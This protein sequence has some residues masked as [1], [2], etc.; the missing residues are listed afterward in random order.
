[1]KEEHRSQITDEKIVLYGQ[2][3]K[4]VSIILAIIAGISLIVFLLSSSIRST[5][6]NPDFYKDNFKKANTYSELINS[7]IPS[8]IMSSTISNDQ[9]TNF[10]AQKGIIY[11]VQHTIPASW[12]EEKM[13]ALIDNVTKFISNSPKTPK[14]VVKLNDMGIYLTQI[15]DGL[16]LVEQII[17]SCEDAGKDTI[18][19]LFNIKIDCKNMSTNLDQ[20]KAE[21]EKMRIKVIN[22]KLVE[23]DISQEIQNAA[24]IFTGI[25][26]YANKVNIYFW[27]SLVVLIISLLLIILL[28]IKNIYN[29]IKYITIPIA[30]SSA[31]MLL[32]ALSTKSS[33]LSSLDNNLQIS[34]TP[35]MK[36]IILNFL[37]VCIV[38][39][40][41]NVITISAIILLISAGI[42][43]VSLFYHKKHLH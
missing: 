17:P 4:I 1:M 21:I 31:I 10:L 3:K 8:L 18:S 20:I 12:V 41:T 39:R 26:D 43:I 33:F 15:G 28:Q 5:I 30:I 35:E 37:H 13:D 16:S 36:S 25:K 2:Y 29:L 6:V 38:D 9:L 19:Q 32:A 34:T 14:V 23:T 22:L 42:Y 40:F 7:G 24:D 11:V 27:T